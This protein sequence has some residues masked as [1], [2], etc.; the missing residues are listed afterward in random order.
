M[1]T[2]KQIGGHFQRMSD[3]IDR[4]YKQKFIAKTQSLLDAKVTAL[5]TFLDASL[6]F[7]NGEAVWNQDLQII[8]SDRPRSATN[9]L[10][11]PEFTVQ[12]AENAYMLFKEYFMDSL[13]AKK[14]AYE[15][16]L[17]DLEQYCTE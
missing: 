14:K 3:G 6:D 12:S 2:S 13:F 10:K 8:D 5:H 11:N 4:F 7:A 1:S 9:P 17:A 15:R 16:G